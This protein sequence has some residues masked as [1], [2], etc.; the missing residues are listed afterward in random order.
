[1]TPLAPPSP[2]YGEGYDLGLLDGREQGRAQARGEI[3]AGILARAAIEERRAM[4]APVV[5]LR[6]ASAAN[7]GW[8]RMLADEVRA[9]AL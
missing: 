7:A 9:G 6:A 2:T 3:V 1:M 4:D 8:L 5:S